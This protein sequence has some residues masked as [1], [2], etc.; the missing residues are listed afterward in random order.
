MRK[1]VM[2]NG[3]EVTLCHPKND[4]GYKRFD[5]MEIALKGVDRSQV[6]YKD[7]WALFQDWEDDKDPAV[8]NKSLRRLYPER[9]SSSTQMFKMVGY[10]VVC[11]AAIALIQAMLY[12]S[13]FH[14]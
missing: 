14:P 1:T 8:V 10:W 4:S 9:Q 7:T 12:W 2:H 11:L 13:G 5:W 3:R 6:S